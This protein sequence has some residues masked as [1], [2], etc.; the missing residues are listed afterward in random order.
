MSVGLARNITGLSSSYPHNTPMIEIKSQGESKLAVDANSTKTTTNKKTKLVSLARF[1]GKSFNSLVYLGIIGGALLHST[2]ASKFVNSIA[3][4]RAV[5]LIT[6]PIT[7]VYNEN[8][9]SLSP[10]DNFFKTFI[11]SK[12]ITDAITL[13][14]INPYEFDINK[15]GYIFDNNAEVKL[16][17]SRLEELKELTQNEDDKLAFTEGLK[18]AKDY[19]VLNAIIWGNSGGDAKN[20]SQNYEPN[21]QHI[22]GLKGKFLTEDRKQ[23]SRGMIKVKEY[24]L[25]E[26]NPKLEF[27]IKLNGREIPVSMSD[28]EG[29]YGA[30]DYISSRSKDGSL[31][32]AIF[33]VGMKKAAPDKV[34]NIFPNNA[35][36]MLENKNYCT[37]PVITLTD[38]ELEKIFKKSPDTLVTV[39]TYFDIS[40]KD[41]ISRMQM[42]SVNWQS[43]EVSETKL[44]EFKDSIRSSIVKIPEEIKIPTQETEK[45]TQPTEILIP[46]KKDKDIQIA[47]AFPISATAPTEV[48]HSETESFNPPNEI[49]EG[50]MYVV[51]GFDEETKSLIISDTHGLRHKISP[52]EVREHL[53]AVVAP[54]EDI[55]TFGDKSIP[56]ALIGTG[57]IL[58]Y[59]LGKKKAK[60]LISNAFKKEAKPA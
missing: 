12:K 13:G 19:F 26:E 18:S 33:S 14:K 29:A 9:Q 21:C 8:E 49:L 3:Q 24:N 54:T 10:Y 53:V 47:S 23:E 32:T 35:P 30:K 1:S 6:N 40:I 59:Y 57:L 51:E 4:S 38:S 31:Y 60:I 28:L 7:D 46:E 27:S 36:I 34:P 50:H 2:W 55:N 5:N 41:T 20:I 11:H 42:R 22:S 39:A 52:E 58:C 44:A 16:L 56:A 43:P 45:T 48:S 37:V 15:S 17:I 25:G